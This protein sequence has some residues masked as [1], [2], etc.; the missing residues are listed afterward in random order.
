MACADMPRENLDGGARYAR[1]RAMQNKRAGQKKKPAP[2]SRAGFF[3]SL[4]S[5]AVVAQQS[6]AQQKLLTAK[7]LRDEIFRRAAR[8]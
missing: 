1:H 6:G 5:L 3:F 7:I 2:I 8:S 4:S